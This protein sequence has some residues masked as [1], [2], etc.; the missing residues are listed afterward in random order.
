MDVGSWYTVVYSFLTAH[1]A[2]AFGICAFLGVFLWKKPWDFLKF[3]FLIFILIAGLYGA[4]RFGETA[5]EG[6]RNKHTM[7]TET[8]EQLLKKQ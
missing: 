8:Q 5:K 1:P 6:V 2:I 4:M 7:A 3:V